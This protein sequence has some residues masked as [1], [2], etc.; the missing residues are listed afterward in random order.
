MKKKKKT[1]EKSAI[2]TIKF[3]SEVQQTNFTNPEGKQLAIVDASLQNV[4]KKTNKEEFKQTSHDIYSEDSDE[5]RED[6]NRGLAIKTLAQR[7]LG[8]H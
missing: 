8:Y 7:L 5:L 6:Y 3:D 1:I 2:P 4:S